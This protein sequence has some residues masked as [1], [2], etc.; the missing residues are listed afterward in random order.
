MY[1]RNS[2]EDVGQAINNDSSTLLSRQSNAAVNVCMYRLLQT[3]QPYAWLCSS[4]QA[5]D[6]V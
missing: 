4:V 6:K 2:T 1:T 3:S 5:L